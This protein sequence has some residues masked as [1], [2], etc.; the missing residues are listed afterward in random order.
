[1]ID[2]QTIKENTNAMREC[3][4]AIGNT[5]DLEELLF[6]SHLSEDNQTLIKAICDELGNAYTVLD[7]C[8][9]GIDVLSDVNRPKHETVEQ[10]ETRTGE[11]YPDDAPVYIKNR[12]VDMEEI[13]FKCMDYLH[14]KGYLSNLGIIVATHHGKP[15]L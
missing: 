15:I 9:Y 8:S 5:P 10:W 12:W 4:D 6:V 2:Y 1:M 13:G 7:V 14:A 11:R 3:R